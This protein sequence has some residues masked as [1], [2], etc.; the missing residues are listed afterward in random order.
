MLGN[1][2][3][4]SS[5][6]IRGFFKNIG[7]SQLIST[8][9]GNM[10]KALNFSNDI[11]WGYVL[12]VLLIVSGL[13][14]TFKLKFANLTQIKEMF[15]IMLEKK[16]GNGISPFQAFCVSA[17]SKVG[18]GSLAGVAIAISLGGPGS[19]FWMWVLTLIVGS[20]SIVENILAQ[21]Y[22]EKKDGLFRGGPAFYMEKAMKKRWM[23]IAFSVL[24]TVTYGLIFNAVQANTMTIA[25]ENFCG[26]DRVRSGLIIVVFTAAVVYGGMKRIAKVSEIIVPLM[27]ASYLL[28]ALFVVG[29]NIG[30]LP[31]V[32]SMIFAN[33]FGLK[34]IGG[35][36]L[37]IIVM[38]GVKRG[39]F[40]NE[41]GMGSTP[42]A[43]ASASASHPAKQGLIQ[44]LGVYVTT[45]GVCTAT[46]F[47]ILFSG[48]LDQ[49]LDGIGYT[50]AAMKVQLG[51]IGDI[52]LLLCIV[53]FA[54]TTI[55]GNYYYGQTNLEYLNADKGL[56]IQIFRVLVLVMVFFGAVRE[57]QFVW[58]AADLFMALMAIFNIYAIIRLRKPA[59][60]AMEHYVN[61]RKIGMDPIFTTN[62][63]DDNTGVECWDE[64]GEVPLE[65]EDE[66][67]VEVPQKAEI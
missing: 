65:D 27:G 36:T 54:Y 18:T 41:A 62:V 13:Y 61:G 3:G 21:I 9:A 55:I 17:G 25:I 28:V 23:G 8:M 48:V 47:I 7:N 12:I 51:S 14:F 59:I 49:N 63:L 24:L 37:G 30:E 6:V 56:K 22:K 46:A 50:Q 58:N 33:A 15:K 57:S 39:L 35:G 67:Y 11:L 53:L 60:Q 19:V 34:A 2:F 45:L 29:K 31:A 40:S 32:I 5:E 44:T 52:F 66:V 10:E 4:H 38:Q 43:G 42:N 1:L 16:E 64:N 20:L 26:I